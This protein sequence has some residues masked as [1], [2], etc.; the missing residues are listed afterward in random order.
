[1]LG[2]PTRCEGLP[3]TCS[4]SYLLPLPVSQMPNLRSA[5]GR[6]IVG[7]LQGTGPPV[8]PREL[9]Q[10]ICRRPKVLSLDQS[11]QAVGGHD[12]WP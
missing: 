3:P 12:S 2:P 9:C 8:S 10:T 7:G 1:M 5:A 4:P 11:A 6:G